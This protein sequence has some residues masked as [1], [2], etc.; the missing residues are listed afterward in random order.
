MAGDAA[1]ESYHFDKRQA[2]DRQIHGWNGGQDEK[3][4]QRIK[5]HG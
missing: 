4:R 5:G 3:K 1:W 2:P